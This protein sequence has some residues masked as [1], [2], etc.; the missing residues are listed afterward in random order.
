MSPNTK[1]G[2]S[3]VAEL[4]TA[5]ES[6]Y[7]SNAIGPFCSQRT[8]LCGVDETWRGAAH[9]FEEWHGVCGAR[10]RLAN[11]RIYISRWKQ[12][13]NYLCGADAFEM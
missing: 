11:R 9:L 13:R 2:C 8:R 1:K 6:A 12:R 10:L 5:V 4:R 7:V 3:H